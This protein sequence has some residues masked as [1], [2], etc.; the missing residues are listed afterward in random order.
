VTARADPDRLADGFRPGLWS[1]GVDAT[2]DPGLRSARLLQTSAAEAEMVK[3]AMRFVRFMVVVTVLSAGA[4]VLG[5]AVLAWSVI[6]PQTGERFTAFAVNMNQTGAGSPTAT[7]DINIR[8]WTPDAQRDRLLEAAK[9]SP[10]ALAS[11]L[12]AAP[13]V[14]SIRTPDSVAYDLHYARQTPSGDGGRRIVLMT[15]RPIGFWEL[16]NQARSVEY[17]FMLIE[18]RVDKNGNGEGKLSTATKIVGE[19][20]GILMLEN[21]DLQPVQLHKVRRLE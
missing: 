17:P 16:R 6:P 2:L 18:L 12:Q 1:A 15:N 4:F 19:E 5:S 13:V 10:K 7:V 20:S 9:D 21:Y 8:S 11:A 3:F 14:G